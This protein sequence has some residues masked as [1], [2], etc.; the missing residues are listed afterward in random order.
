MNAANFK[1][2]SVAIVSVFFLLLISCEKE[3]EV[4]G[5]TG[6]GNDT[7]GNI[8]GKWKRYNSIT[9]GVTTFHTHECEAEHGVDYLELKVDNTLY[10]QI[11]SKDNGDCFFN[12]DESGTYSKSGNQLTIH[13]AGETAFTTE[14]TELT[15]TSL[16][17]VSQYVDEEDS[18]ITQTYTETFRR[19]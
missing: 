17:I 19:L 8:V 3:P 1:I 18:N 14:I 9:D 11:Y 6:G 12:G 2:L 7:S 4:N 13:L 15:E 16:T 5:G 10:N